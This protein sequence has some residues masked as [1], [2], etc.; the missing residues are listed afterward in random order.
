MPA[1]THPDLHGNYSQKESDRLG[2]LAVSGARAAH[3]AGH[4]ARKHGGRRLFRYLGIS[5][6]DFIKSMATRPPLPL[7]QQVSSSWSP[8][9]IGRKRALFVVSGKGLEA[10]A[11]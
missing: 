11:A 5:A 8:G 1:Q 4:R 10:V 3:D 6:S 9:Q 7:S 2:W